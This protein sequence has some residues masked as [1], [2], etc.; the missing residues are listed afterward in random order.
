MYS[1]TNYVINK[2]DTKP[3]NSNN[4]HKKVA[5]L[6]IGALLTAGVGAASFSGIFFTTH[7][8]TP[9]IAT[10]ASLVVVLG[11]VDLTIK[12]CANRKKQTDHI[13]VEGEKSPLVIKDDQIGENQKTTIILSDIEHELFKKLCDFTREASNK[14]LKNYRELEKDIRK[15]DI[16]S[17]EQL[18]KVLSYVK[19]LNIHSLDI[20]NLVEKMLVATIDHR[21]TEV[22][23][24]SIKD[25]NLAEALKYFIEHFPVPPTRIDRIN[26]LDEIAESFLA[27]FEIEGARTV[28]P[29]MPKEEKGMLEDRIKGWELVVQ[30]LTKKDAQEACDQ[31]K[32]LW[33]GKEECFKA[34]ADYYFK[35]KEKENLIVV[36]K[37]LNKEVYP[38]LATSIEDK[39][40]QLSQNSD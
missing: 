34:L 20:L 12:I 40:K 5:A 39:I 15:A 27:R 18:D 30:A 10:T 38:G 11:A 21:H 26:L 16:Y 28:L 29:Y 25:G 3:E 13:P 23:K 33:I 1:I 17:I 4:T 6:V 32:K 35:G 36:Y 22:I 37:A 19:E 8:L 7:L 9:S 31:A 2:A 24:K 14:N